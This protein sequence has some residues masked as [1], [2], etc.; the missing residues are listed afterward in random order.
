MKLQ[1]LRYVQQELPRRKNELKIQFFDDLLTRVHAALAVGGDAAL[2]TVLRRQ[3]RAALIDEFQDT[4]P[5]QYEIFH[6]VFT[7]PES[8]LFLI[9]DPKQAIYGF[10]G[11]DIFTYLK[12]SQQANRAY[13]LTENWRSESGLVR[14]VNTV[15]RCFG[16]ALRIPRHPVPSSGSQG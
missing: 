1:A 8:H 13:T 15:C 11:A 5:L 6:R 9:G 4:D 7:G 16:L 14:A 3:Y 2:A 10:R 12:A